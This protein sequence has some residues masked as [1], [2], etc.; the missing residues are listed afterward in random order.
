[1]QMRHSRRWMSTTLIMAGLPLLA[2]SAPVYS[3]APEAA[4]VAHIDGSELS[5]VTLTE[6]AMQRIDIGTTAVRQELVPVR[7]QRASLADGFSGVV[8]RKIVPYS[9]LI[10]DPR[11]GIWVYTNPRPRTFVRHRV[12]VYGIT[13]DRTVLRE[14]PAVGT[15]VV[16]LGAAEIY[17]TE[18]ALRD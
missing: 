3:T 16:T 17:G 5:G 6:K 12:D 8:A 4:Q 1:M 15:E 7:E 18:L 2:C 10:Y 14:G 9:S 13:G 11:G